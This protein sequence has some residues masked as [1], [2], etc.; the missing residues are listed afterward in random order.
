[1]SKG[2][3][4]I[5]DDESRMRRLIK[6]FLEAADYS[7]LE[8][9]DGKAAFDIFCAQQ[10][11]ISL[12]VLDVMMPEMDGREVCREIR[13][14]SAVP[15]IML[16]ALSS[17]SDE[18]SG[19]GIGAD[20]Y[21]TKPFSPGVFVARVE[22]LL[23]RSAK[24]GGDVIET[25][26][27]KVDKSAHAVFVDGREVYLSLKEYEL[28]LYLLENRGSTMSREKIL[29][30]VWSFDY[31]GDGRTVDTHIT[32]LRKK[33]GRCGGMLSTVRG[34]GYKFEK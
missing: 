12:V 27:L 6:D 28:L 10:S 18:I 24:S 34:V 15:V 21:I 14:V 22:A 25:E 33:L 19:L 29:D 13:R 23:R 2:T 9:A 11:R 17:E 31:F 1:M 16:T 5:A 26:G 3:I 4:L 20:E 8:A 30:S 7:V 32:K